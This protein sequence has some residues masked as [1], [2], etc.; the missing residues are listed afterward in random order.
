VVPVREELQ[1][2][3]VAARDGIAVLPFTNLSSDPENEFFCDGMT[4][5][6]INVLAKID[7]LQV[8]ART[9]VFA[10]KG[11]SEDV[12]QIAAKL[13]VQKIIEGSVRKSGTRIRITAQLI[14]AADGYHIWSES[15]DRN[16]EDIFE[17]QDEIAR[18]IANKLRENLTTLQHESRLSEAPTQNLEAYKK[19]LL[20][21]Q[22]IERAEPEEKN[23]ALDLLQEA[24]LMD[25]GFV[26]VHALLAFEY[27]FMGQTG[28]M[29]ANEASV[30]AKEHIEK[31]LALD[32]ENVS[33]MVSLSFI[34]LAEWKWDDGFEL[35]QRALK[36][37]P[38]N[39][40][41]QMTAAEYYLLF[42]NREKELEHAT[43]AYRLDP[44]SSNTLG[45]T[46]RH[47]L[48][49]GKYNEAL[50]FA[51]EGMR[52]DPHNLV[53]RC[54]RA[55]ALDATGE[56]ETAVKEMLETY[57]VTG[58]HPLVL[59]ALGY[60]YARLK[61]M[62]K[63]NAILSKFFEMTEQMP[64]AHFDFIFATIYLTMGD[65][66]KFHFYYDRGIKRRAQWIVQFYG[67]EMLRDMWYDEH[68][69]E[70]RRKLGLPVFESPGKSS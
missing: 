30:L 33:A 68:V 16:P 19:Y 5:E 12:R 38:N 13:N 35:V 3:T 58:D 22:L 18:T 69:R 1:G 42:L 48:S 52:L 25:P 41:A 70:S 7:G 57:Q 31:A 53:S 47:F 20:G 54:I 63:A 29:P 6:L 9:S 37:N 60:F 62:E 32:P 39:S 66:G 8:I 17:V 15:Y 24:V 27:N 45:E 46:A 21:M 43:A 10:F 50:E 55:Y 34:K 67:S 51:D 28:Q 23:K 2:K 4:E 59:M 44:L 64:D 56:G 11:K 36:I 14:N 61:Q 65:I 49:I 40:M 26:N